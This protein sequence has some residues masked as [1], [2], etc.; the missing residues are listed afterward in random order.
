MLSNDEV[1]KIFESAM[2]D[3]TLLSTI[4]VDSLLS[5]IEDSKN[6]YLENKTTELINK[7]I[8]DSVNAF[9]INIETKEL[10][11]DKLIGYR[12]V[13]EL[14]ELHKGKHIRWIRKNNSKLTNGGIIVDIKFLDEGVHILCM[15]NG[16]RFVQIKF[17]DCVIY[18]KMSEAEQLIVMAY[19]YVD[20]NDK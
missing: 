10:Y 3:P 9:P 14:N 2:K 1:S 7:D 8:F 20:S 12:L 15:G 5:S 16:K 19:E 11:C 4:D 18:Q 6:D 13:L 17:D